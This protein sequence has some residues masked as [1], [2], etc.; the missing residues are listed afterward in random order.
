MFQ[1]RFKAS[2]FGFCRRE[3]RSVFEKSASG[4]PAAARAAS[5][6]SSAT[7]TEAAA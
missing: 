6:E 4:L 7:A 3:A 5:A 2:R 1:V